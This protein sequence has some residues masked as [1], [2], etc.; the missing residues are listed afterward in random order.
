MEKKDH[1]DYAAAYRE[2]RNYSKPNRKHSI[3]Y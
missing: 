1:T 2:Y 3:A